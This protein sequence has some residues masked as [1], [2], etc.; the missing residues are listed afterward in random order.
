MCLDHGLED[1]ANRDWLALPCEVVRNCEDGTQIVRR[2]P[3]FSSKEAIVEIK[4]A[5]L[6]TNVK[7]TTDG[8]ELVVGTGDLRAYNAIN[9]SV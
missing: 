5:N 9:M 3:P 7:S 6:S 8:V 4:P 2:M 1:V